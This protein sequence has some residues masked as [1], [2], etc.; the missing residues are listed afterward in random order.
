M[1]VGISKLIP[2]ECIYKDYKDLRRHWKNM[3]SG[4]RLP[5]ILATALSTCVS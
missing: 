5:L 3:V 1:V 4:S 2:D